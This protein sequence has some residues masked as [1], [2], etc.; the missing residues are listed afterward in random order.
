M[1][2]TTFLRI[3]FIGLVVSILSVFKAFAAAPEAKMPAMIS[4]DELFFDSE[5]KIV[6]ANGDVEIV[7]GDQVLLADVVTYDQTNDR[8]EAKGK[9]S[10]LDKTGNVYFANYIE[11]QDQFK[12]G[13]IENFS[14]RLEEDTLVAA[15]RAEKVS[16]SQT[17]L[18]KAVY[19][20]C[21]V[22]ATD[23]LKSPL[24]QIK[25]N[26]AKIDQ[27][28]QQVEYRH[29]FFE[30]HEVPVLYMPYLSHP[31]PNADRRSG[32][33]TPTYSN[34]S[35]FGVRV[36]TPF[37]YNIAPDKDMTF[38]PGFTQERG[39]YLISQYRQ[40]TRRGQYELGGSITNTDQMNSKGNIVPGDQIRGHIEGKGL[41]V[42]DNDWNV[43]FR[44]KRSS[45]DTY[46]RRYDLDDDDVLISR[47]FA[48]KVSA[49]RYALVQ[50]I[51]FQGL[52]EEDDP[53][54][55]P[56]ILPQGEFHMRSKPGF[57]ASHF[58]LDGNIL[59]LGRSEGISSRRISLKGGWQVPHITRNGQVIEFKTSLRGDGYSVDNVPDP[60]L[61]EAD[62][63]HDDVVGR[64][65]PQAELLWSLP[66]VRP[67]NNRQYFLEP[68][69]HIIVSPYGG[70]PDEIPN[71]D[72][73]D[74]EFADDNLFASNLFTGYDVVEDG[75]RFNYG[76]RGGVT[77][78]RRGQIDF[79]V[80]QH[81]RAKENIHFS[82]RTGLDERFSDFVGRVTYNKDGRMNVSYRVRLD[83]D[84]LT[85]NK[86]AVTASVDLQPVAFSFDYLSLDENFVDEGKFDE[87]REIFSANTTVDLSQRWSWSNRGYRDLENGDWISAGT[88]LLYKGAC[89]DFLTTYEREFTQD[90]DILPSTTISFK[91]SL[92]NL[93]AA[94]YSE[95]VSR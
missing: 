36:E 47:G 20:P 8:V 87:K 51:S 53:D 13:I 70:N 4:A 49:R 16:E 88:S 45:D 57:H 48:E 62:G 56:V 89:V 94:K 33:L 11:L 75:P 67:G 64:V 83:K 24:W 7:Q 26:E 28:K 23:F 22:C 2:M 68:K 5:T 25:A 17:N 66:M 38:T 69:T 30:V 29:A 81:Y 55:T 92:K 42:F 52:R 50:A 82:T 40:L 44:G 91:V 27:E 79:L 78:Y 10:V 34:N 76:L 59:A 12:Q 95:E 58:S 54:T 61:K 84:E 74:V 43:G 72:S 63:R 19:S 18:E 85:T 65:I 86:S 35:F 32:L 6:I 37:Y 14:A 77:D 1:S 93:G 71:E 3:I 60:T 21:P 90:R 9:I 80:G 46:L 39:S 41:F 15:R 31:T 73:Q